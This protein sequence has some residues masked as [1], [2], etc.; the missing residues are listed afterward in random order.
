[1][2]KKEQAWID[3]FKDEFAHSTRVDS[4]R[5]IDDRVPWDAIEEKG[6][7]LKIVRTDEPGWFDRLKARWQKLMPKKWCSEATAAIEQGRPLPGTEPTVPKW[8]RRPY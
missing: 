7:E 8:W 5:P 6:V 3:W 1:M 4:S 2:T